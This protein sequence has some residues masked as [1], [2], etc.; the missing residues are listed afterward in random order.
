MGTRILKIVSGLLCLALAACDRSP[1]TSGRQPGEPVKSAAAAAAILDET[2]VDGTP[3]QIVGRENAC[4][5]RSGATEFP[6]RP[7]S[8]CFFL[9]RDGKVQTFRYGD[10]GV[11]WVVILAGTAVSD[12]DRRTWNLGEAEVCGTESQAVLQKNG[13][14]LAKSVHSGGVYCRDKGV[15]E[16][17]FWAFAHDPE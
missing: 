7:K 10:A 8:P 1:E 13:L 15:D 12:A 16:K 11:D 9:R 6:L 4:L 5:L 17:E 2:T 14:R 3:L